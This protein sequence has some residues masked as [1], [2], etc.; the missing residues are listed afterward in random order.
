MLE[1]EDGN[2]GLFL[3]I[4]VLPGGY[5]HANAA[6]LWSSLT[7]VV[8]GVDLDEQIPEHDHWPEYGPDFT[9]A[10]EPTLAKDNNRS[11]YIEECI[12]KIDSERNY[13]KHLVW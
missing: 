8:A 10:V 1:R 13:I 6:Q 9:A 7:A 12:N 3:K 11:S 4:S 5:K 2:W